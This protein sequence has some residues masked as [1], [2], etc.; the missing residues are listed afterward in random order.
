MLLVWKGGIPTLVLTRVL[1]TGDE[2]VPQSQPGA[3]PCRVAPGNRWGRGTEEEMPCEDVIDF[4]KNCDIVG[5]TF[6]VSGL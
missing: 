3:G 1:S 6:L 4:L 2:T 5:L